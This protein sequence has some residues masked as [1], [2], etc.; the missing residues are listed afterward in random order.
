MRLDKNNPATGP[1]L[2]RL[3]RPVVRLALRSGFSFR[4]IAHLLKV[5]MLEECEGELTRGGE[6][7]SASK[8]SAVT[9]M[10]RNDIKA[11][12]EAPDERSPLSNRLVA[13]VLNRWEQDKRFLDGRGRPRVLSVSGPNNDFQRLVSSISSHIASGAVL[14]ELLRTGQVKKTANGI[15]LVNSV[16]LASKDAFRGMD[17][18]ARNVES[19]CTGVFENLSLGEMKNLHIRTTYDNVYVSD[20]PR[21]RQW[22]IKEGTRFHKKM[23]AMLSKSDADLHPRSSKDD[24]AGA[25]IAIGTFSLAQAPTKDEPK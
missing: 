24:E 7:I 4:E 1:L 3:L 16:A 6:R 11:L 21:L 18:L 23:R 5:E 2:R 19:L 10:N 22:L 13:R 14:F 15:K 9:G 25:T 8:I 17:L 12:K 20:L